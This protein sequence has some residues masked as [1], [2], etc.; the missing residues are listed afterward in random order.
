[1]QWT[2]SLPDEFRRRRGY[3]LRAHLPELIW[4]NVDE[5]FMNEH[6]ATVGKLASMVVE[7]SSSEVAGGH[8]SHETGRGRSPDHVVRASADRGATPEQTGNGAAGTSPAGNVETGPAD[9]VAGSTPS[10]A[11]AGGL[12]RRGGVDKQSAIPSADS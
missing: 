3:E 11:V 12:S 4:P 5:A 8:A 1:M 7:M 9:R 6:C 2:P 10:D